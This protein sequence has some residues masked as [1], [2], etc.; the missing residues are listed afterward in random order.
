MSIESLELCRLFFYA[1][2]WL[3]SAFI[4]GFLVGMIIMFIL[5]RP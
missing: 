1:G 5:R 4:V 2:V 3:S